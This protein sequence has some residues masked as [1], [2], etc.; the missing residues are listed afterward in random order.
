MFDP[1]YIFIGASIAVAIL[2]ALAAFRYAAKNGQLSDLQE[3]SKVIFD[4]DEPI[5][6]PTDAFPGSRP[7]Q[8]PS[9]A[10]SAHSPTH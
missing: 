10:R 6:Q 3:G 2:A 1:T 5:G 9:R 7:G 8:V 4:Q